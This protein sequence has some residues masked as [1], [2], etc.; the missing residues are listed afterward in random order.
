MQN[1]CWKACSKTNTRI[2]HIGCIVSEDVVQHFNKNTELETIFRVNSFC[3]LNYACR[4]QS[5]QVY[6]QSS[7]IAIL[8]QMS[9]VLIDISCQIEW[10]LLHLLTHQCNGTSPVCI[11][12]MVFEIQLFLIHALQKVVVPCFRELGPHKSRK[13]NCISKTINVY[14]RDLYRY[15]GENLHIPMISIS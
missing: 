7:R 13:N 6:S 8:S 1:S 12:C 5:V 4:V 14:K 11:R 9:R 3:K 15:V 2:N 10:C